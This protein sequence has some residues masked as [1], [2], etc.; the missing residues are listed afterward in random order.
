M[1][2]TELA[3][4]PKPATLL[5]RSRRWPVALTLAAMLAVVVVLLPL[6][7]LLVRAGAAD[8]SAW[9]A[10]LRPSTL[11]LLGGSA[12]LAAGSALLS[13]ALALPLAWLTVCSDLPLRRVWAALAMLPLVIPTYIAAFGI[14]AVLG[15][16]GML[17]QLLAPLGVERLPS[18]YGFWGALA[19]I[20][21]CS[22]PYVL[23]AARAAL[24]RCDPALEESARTLGDGPLRV[25]WRVQLPQL[26]PGVAAGGL[27]VALYA[28][29]DFGAVSLLQFNSFARAIYTQYRA[30]FSR[31][32]AALL[33]LLLVLLTVAV[34]LVESRVRGAG[35]TARSTA[36]CA[37]PRRP[38]RLGRWR[39]PALAFC[40]V[41]CGLALGVPLLALCYW[42]AR[43]L[44]NGQALGPVWAE[45][46]HTLLAAGP[47]AAL[48]VAAALPLALLAARHAS[49]LSRLLERCAYLGYAL[50]G[51]VVALALVFFGATYA[52]LLYQT[53]PMLQMAYL[54]RF[55]PQAVGGLRAG[56]G[57]INPHWEEAGRALGGSPARVTATI[58]GPLLAPA[59]LA[60]VTTVF[61]STMKELP[62]TLLLGPTGFGTLATG[63]WGAVAEAFFAR[64]A[65]P[66]LFLVL[67]ASVGIGLIL[68]QEDRAA[69]ARL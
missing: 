60:S 24:L 56:L 67:A 40:A 11:R 20:T 21:L 44:S 4:A 13:C 12:A 49:L 55:L 34:L 1:I 32:G 68:A 45:A 26:R 64:A 61:L 66:A 37:R 52:P 27:L 15:P 17:Q 9:A 25:F 65:A 10:L 14:V 33:A 8:A 19:A 39:W 62:A 16:R 7:Y 36:A 2:S 23:L 38:V 5:R 47:A 6:A 46:G 54:V 31:E 63:V 59:A 41:V 51:I 28:L 3:T 18:I 22:Y 69:G 50:P 57:Q 29:S 43:G 48:A 58:T 30:S 42:L 35:H 53:L